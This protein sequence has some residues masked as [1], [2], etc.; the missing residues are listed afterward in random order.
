M[1][2]HPHQGDDAQ[3][4]QGGDQHQENNGDDR[5]MGMVA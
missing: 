1:H 3:H 5:M 2:P 4:H